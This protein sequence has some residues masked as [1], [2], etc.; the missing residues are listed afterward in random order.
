M[1]VKIAKNQ[2]NIV[3]NNNQKTIQNTQKHIQKT[4]KHR[5]QIDQKSSPKNDR[6]FEE[7]I[8]S[9]NRVANVRN[10]FARIYSAWHNKMTLEPLRIRYFDKYYQGAKPF[11]E[12]YGETPGKG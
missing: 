7:I 4:I 1:P 6:N 8:D 5:P 2:P 3:E 9:V 10:P 11:Q 12:L